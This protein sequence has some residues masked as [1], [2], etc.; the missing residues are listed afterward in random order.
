MIW[1]REPALILGVVQA[2]IALAVSL[3]FGLS[4][5][6]VGAILA[7]SAAVMALVTRSQVTPTAKEPEPEPPAEP[8]AD[9]TDNQ[10][11]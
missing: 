6:Q 10:A 8:P 4:T 3:G 5:E 9:W 1:K 7:V 2:I 11:A